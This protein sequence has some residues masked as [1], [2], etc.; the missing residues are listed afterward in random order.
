MSK[1]TGSYSE[2]FA[3][4]QEIQTQIETNKLDV[5][6]LAVVLKEASDLLKICKEKLL[7]VDEETKKII[8]E[9]Q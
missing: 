6:E 7:V 8:D 3:R 9:I 5:D 1:K 2:A 4:L